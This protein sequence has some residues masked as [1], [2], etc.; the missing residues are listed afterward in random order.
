MRSR[1]I[2]FDLDSDEGKEEDLPGSHGTVPHRPG[3][4]IA[5]GEGGRGEEGG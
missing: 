3:D 4:S 5:I 2:R 1:S